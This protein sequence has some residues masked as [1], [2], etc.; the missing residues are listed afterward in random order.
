MANAA[1]P[2][3]AAQPADA[4]AEAERKRRRQALELQRERVL[5]ERTSNPHRRSALE[6]A[7]IDIEEKLSELGWSIHL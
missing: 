6:T 3:P 2:P 4:V 7:L 5:S 1:T